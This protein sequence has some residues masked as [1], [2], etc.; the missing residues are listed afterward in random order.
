MNAAQRAS[1]PKPPPLPRKAP[2]LA[3]AKVADDD[4][5]D[6]EATAIDAQML[7]RVRA[8]CAPKHSEIR[9]LRPQPPRPPRP[10]AKTAEPK[11]RVET[12]A[13]A[14]AP[15]GDA[16]AA[17]APAATAAPLPAPAA[18]AAP[19]PAIDVP[20]P[21]PALLQLEAEVFPPEAPPPAEV[22]VEVVESVED[23]VLPM[24][25][26]ARVVLAI[27]AV[28]LFFAYLARA[29]F[30]TLRG[31]LPVLTKRARERIRLEWARAMGRERPSF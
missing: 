8:D 4:D 17:P 29:A 14:P 11:P 2:A 18:T 7:E 25:P 22:E 9:A 13:A 19:P 28:P 30:R 6:L 23:D 12:A 26:A 3:I 16:V 20:P 10:A 15:K 27:R 24:A 1:R 5:L 31:A 21:P